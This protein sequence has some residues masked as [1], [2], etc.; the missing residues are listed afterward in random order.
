MFAIAGA[1][2]A[3]LD[4]GA[5]T[6]GIDGEVPGLGL[7]LF[8]GRV[9]DGDGRAWGAVGGGVRGEGKGHV[10]VCFAVGGSVLCAPPDLVQGGLAE[11]GDA[12][13]FEAP[14]MRASVRVLRAGRGR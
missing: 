2:G 7:G 14:V 12:E 9:R 4:R 10:I 8:R 11:G 6:I 3:I 13:L 5:L 1:T